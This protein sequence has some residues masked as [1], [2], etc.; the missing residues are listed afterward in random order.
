MSGASSEAWER[1]RELVHVWNEKGLEAWA[2]A[3]W[4]PDIVW[5]EPQRF[6]DAGVHKGREASLQRMRERFDWIGEVRMELVDVQ[7]S[8]SAKRTMIEVII[9]SRGRQSGAEATQR[10]FLVSE[11]EDG[12]TVLL[13][14]FLDR[15]DALAALA[16]S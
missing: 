11:V 10:E 12:R 2:S 8:Q 3:A 6:P 14:E 1:A 16:E 13:L 9:H 15:D 5:H 7:Q 4:S